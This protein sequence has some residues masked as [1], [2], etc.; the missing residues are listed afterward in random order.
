MHRG[1]LHPAACIDTM[2]TFVQELRGWIAT[3]LGSHGHSAPLCSDPFCVAVRL[4]IGIGA[5]AQGQGWRVD[6][7]NVRWPPALE[8]SGKGPAYA[9]CAGW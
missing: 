4:V 2:A 7:P 1:V 6:E 8:P 5:C 3:A 9:G